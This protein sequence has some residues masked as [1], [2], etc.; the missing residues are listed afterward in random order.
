MRVVVYGSSLNMAGIATSLKAVASLEVICVNPRSPGARQSLNELK[1]AVIVFG[2]SETSSD[3]NVSLLHEQPGLVLVGVDPSSD[4]M[5]V[6]S[7][8]SRQA[9]SIADLINVI[10]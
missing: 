2:L 10:H 5:L 4:E 3:L 7:S 6:L 1:P 9:L 8:H